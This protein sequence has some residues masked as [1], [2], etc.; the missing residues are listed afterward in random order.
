[1]SAMK[2][3]R[4]VSL[5]I[6]IPAYNEEQRLTS[7]LAT[8]IEYAS[9]NEWKWVEIII[10]NDGSLDGTAELVTRS[11]RR[12]PRLRLV[13]YQPNRGKGNAVREGMLHATGD[14]R[15]FSDAD[16]STPLAEVKTLF[17]AARS[18]HADIV[19]AS[20][21]LDRSLIGR[22]QSG[23]REF[24]GRIFNVCV[25]LLTGLP[26]SDT[27]C[28]FKLFS[29]KSAEQVFRLQRLDGFGFDV[30]VLF[31]G[32]QLGIRIAEV[33]TRWSHADGTKVSMFG[34]SFRMFGDLFRI[35]YSWILGLYGTR[36]PRREWERTEQTLKNIHTQL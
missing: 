2:D 3:C 4:E 32:K 33:A 36:A 9:H 29:A 13:N 28:G 23:L 30:E 8:V 25:Q 22:H 12:Y 20:R 34:D 35:R 16:L 10:V 15:L 6:V 17:C 26:L 14:W 21:A 27:Q 18:R 31:I 7:T 1:M 11:M 19:I 24:A 5:S